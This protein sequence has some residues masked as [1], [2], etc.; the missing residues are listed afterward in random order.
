ML[1]QNHKVNGW[2][3]VLGLKRND[4]VSFEDALDFSVFNYEKY[5]RPGVKKQAGSSTLHREVQF[6]TVQA[7][8]TASWHLAAQVR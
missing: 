2:V 1:V 3:L 5:R 8:H 7:H 4:T 6:T